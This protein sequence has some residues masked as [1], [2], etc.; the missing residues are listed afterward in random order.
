MRV[1]LRQPQLN[2]RRSADLDCSE[3]PAAARE[4]IAT[5][6]PSA[7][8]ACRAATSRIGVDMSASLNRI[9]WPCAARTPA[10]TAAPLPRLTPGS[11]TITF[12]SPRLRTSWGV[13]SV[14]PS[15]DTT[16]S[17]SVVTSIIRAA[18]EMMVGTMRSASLYAGTTIES[19]GDSEAGSVAQRWNVVSV[20]TQPSAAGSSR[21]PGKIKISSDLAGDGASA[22][23]G[24]SLDVADPP[25]PVTQ[26]EDDLGSHRA[27]RRGAA[28]PHRRSGTSLARAQHD[29]LPVEAVELDAQVV[30]GRDARSN[31]GGPTRRCAV[32]RSG[33]SVSR[34]PSNAG[35]VNHTSRPPRSP[36]A[37]RMSASFARSQAAA[38]S[39]RVVGSTMRTRSAASSDHVTVAPRDSGTNSVAE[40][41]SS[42]SA[43]SPDSRTASDRAPMTARTASAITTPAASAIHRFSVDIEVNRPVPAST[44]V[45]VS[46]V[47]SS[48][49]RHSSRHRPRHA[50]HLDDDLGAGIERADV[51]LGHTVEERHL[52]RVDP[53]RRWSPSRGFR[54]SPRRRDRREPDRPRRPP[55]RSRRER[56]RPGSRRRLRRR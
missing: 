13:S 8:R 30:C 26:H 34:A 12:R 25:V 1:I 23:V 43:P 33:R 47:D 18:I 51:D 38:T 10:R 24:Q 4:P 11:S 19:S 55:R 37:A 40:N 46:T 17:K 2:T 27:R 36:S 22:L 41:A 44:P 9:W 3:A 21:D 48:F 20:M 42:G 35:P 49:T 16:I 52:D 32:A 54:R 28:A 15:S 14:E 45:S 7:R 31:R 6:A 53:G 56:C 39:S 29:D 50:E 5:S